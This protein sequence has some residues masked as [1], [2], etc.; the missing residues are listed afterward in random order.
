MALAIDTFDA[1]G[2]SNEARCKLLPKKSNIFTFHYMVK[3]VNQL[4]VTN[5]TE[6]LSFKSGRTMWVVKLIKQD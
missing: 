5:K 3:A 6:R 4:Y 2:L 1:R